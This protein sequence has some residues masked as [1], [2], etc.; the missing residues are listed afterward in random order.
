L[1]INHNW[2][3]SLLAIILESTETRI[4]LGELPLGARILI[5]TKKDWR[6]AVVSQ[7]G[8]EKATLIVCSPT[9]KTYRLRRILESEIIFD[10]FIPILKIEQAEN[11]RENFSKYDLR[12]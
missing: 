12:W 2:L 3:F 7:F 5:R 1:C 4:T 9:G 8:E 10:G 11:W 6:S